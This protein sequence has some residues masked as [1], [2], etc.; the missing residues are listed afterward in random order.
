MS[1]I[2]YSTSDSFK[3]YFSSVSEQPTEF[4]SKL[5]APSVKPGQLYVLHISSLQ[6]NCLSWLTNH[7][8]KGAVKRVAVCA[9]KPDIAE[10]LECVRLGAKGYCNS[11]MQ[12]THYQQLIRLLLNDQSWFSPQLLQQAFAL[13]QKSIV[14]KDDAALLEALT[15]RE[16]DVALAV[17]EGLSNK[18]IAKQFDISEN[19]VKTHLTNTFNKLELKDR[20]ALV[21]HLKQG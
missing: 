3:A 20:V 12:P 1:L 13:A 4:H 11:Y 19:T 6:E 14:K 5:S 21:L 8:F 16:K 7:A 2:V 18:Q 17:S 10:M 9:D 15:P